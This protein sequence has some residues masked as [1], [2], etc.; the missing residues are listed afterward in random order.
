MLSA[1]A[2]LTPTMS[3]PAS[4]GP[5][6]A[7]I[8][9]MSRELDAGFDQGLRDDVVDHLDVRAARDFGN[10]AAEARVEIGLARHH[11]RAHDA[12]VVDHGGG[13]LVARGLDTEDARHQDFGRSY[14]VEPG[15]RR[16]TPAS[17][18]PYARESTSYAHMTSASSPVSA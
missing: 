17:N 3:A 13:R 7:A 8:T 6:T 1:L 15:T 11:R 9:S 5:W 4:P 12:A 2:A 10:D 14:T 18:S 16:S